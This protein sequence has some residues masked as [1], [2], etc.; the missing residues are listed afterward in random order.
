MEAEQGNWSRI[1]KSDQVTHKEWVKES[2]RIEKVN[3]MAD[4][5]PKHI[6]TLNVNDLNISINRK[7]AK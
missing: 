6:I 7:L 5:S 3:K 2:K 4:L 1:L